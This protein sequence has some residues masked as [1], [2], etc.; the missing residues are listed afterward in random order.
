MMS[1]LQLLRLPLRSMPFMFPFKSYDFI[2]FFLN[3][4]LITLDLN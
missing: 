4:K 2:L 1:V 3:K